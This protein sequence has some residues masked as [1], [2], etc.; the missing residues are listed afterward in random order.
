MSK[1]VTIVLKARWA[2]LENSVK[3]I[4]SYL[5]IHVI[6]GLCVLFAMLVGGGILFREMFE[7]LLQQEPFGAP[8][9]ERLV[10]IVLLAFFS[11]LVFSNLII[12]LTTTY[13]SRDTE[14]LFEYPISSSSVF[15]IKLIESIFYSS[16]AFVLL[17][18]PLFAAYGI[19]KDA[20]LGYYPAAVLLG[21]PYLVIPACLGA[22]VTMIVSALLPAKRARGYSIGLVLVG[23]AVAVGVVRLMG[24]RNLVTDTETDDF[25]QIMNML[26]V[27]NA[28]LLPNYWLARGLKAASEGQG[29]TCLWWGWCLLITAGLALTLCFWLAPWIYFR[30][31]VLAREASSA[32]RN[33]ASRWSPFPYFDRLLKPLSPPTRALIS[34]DMRTFWRDPAQW[35]QLVVLFGLLVIYVAN[36]RGLTGRLAALENFFKDWPVF[37]SFFNLGATC[38]VICILTTRFIYPMLSLEGKQYWVVGLA[39]FPK[40][41][42]VWEKVVLCL[43]VSLVLAIVLI[44]FSNSRLEV[45]PA[46]GWVGLVTVVLL[47]FGLTSLAV[48]LGAI[49]PDFRQDNPARIANGVGGTMNIVLSLFYIGLVLALALPPTFMLVRGLNAG[50]P[51]GQALTAT[52]S[53]GYPYIAGYVVAHIVAIVLPLS[54]GLKR[55]ENLEI[56][57]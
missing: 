49:F 53:L 26:N 28:P 34:K 19:S 17:S 12:T 41:N 52:V 6:V 35:S 55:W 25:A 9:M 7:F 2:M 44:A 16:W 39:P 32:S 48:G 42:L 36:I 4:R 21:L 1:P 45:A 14:F 30:G 38:F 13:I 3:S 8:L 40:R 29:D 50:A 22:M 10:A 33:T 43:S 18:M 51:L 20:P 37:L 11:M 57:L 23:I 46:L 15:A 5:W 27:G 54:I 24:L 31:W 56:H 47:S